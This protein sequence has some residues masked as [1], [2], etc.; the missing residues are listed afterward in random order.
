MR[1]RLLGIDYGAKRIGLALSDPLGMFASGLQTLDNTSEKQVLRALQA[2]IDQHQIEHLVIGLPL[3]TTGEAGPAT[4]AVQTFG[5][6][7]AVATGL[8]ITYED[9]R[10][11]SVIAQQSLREQGVQPSRKKHLIDQTSAALILQQYLDKRAR[12]SEL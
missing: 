3:K 7:L 1:G 10:F 8:P 5:E 4:E 11:T 9:E 6:Q 2:I 12:L